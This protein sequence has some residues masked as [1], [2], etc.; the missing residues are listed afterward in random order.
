MGK[1]SFKYGTASQLANAP[2][3]EGTFYVISDNNSTDGILYA[4]LN[5]KRICFGD[6]ASLV[7]DVSNLESS[8]P[9]KVSE[10]TNDSGFLTSFT[11][12]DPTVPAWAKATTKPTYTAT[13]VGAAAT[14]HTHTSIGVSNPTGDGQVSTAVNQVQLSASANGGSTINTM[15]ITSTSTTIHNIV[16][17]TANGDAAN[18]KYVDDSIAGITI[19]TV[20]TNVSSFTNDSGYLTLATLPVYN[21]TVI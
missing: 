10:L 15:Q 9:T 8:I 18:K 19:P 21:G 13:E 7:D 4:D 16:T 12:T 2:Y 6:V 14:N 17:P 1:V 5:N 20:P 11:E 3:L